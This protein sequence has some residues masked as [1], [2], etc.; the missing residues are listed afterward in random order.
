MILTVSLNSAFQKVLVFD[1]YKEGHVLR[2]KELHQSA[3]GKG[4]NV[5]RAVKNLGGE[6]LV[7]GFVGGING[8]LMKEMLKDEGIKEHLTL[9]EANTRVCTTIISE[10]TNSTTELIE[11]SGK[12]SSKDAASF[13]KEFTSSLKHAKIAAIS[14]TLPPGCDE[15]LYVELVSEAVKRGVKVFVDIWGK[16]LLAAFK[17]KPKPYLVKMNDHEF[18]DTFGERKMQDVFTEFLAAGIEIVIVTFGK[19]G[20]VASVKEGIFGAI[21]E[22][23]TPVNAIGA[24]D[25]M[26]GGFCFAI[27][28]G[29]DI[30]ETLKTGTGSAVASTQT[31]LPA[32][33]TKEAAEKFAKQ[34][35]VKKLC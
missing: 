22:K 32:V 4:I 8:K 17:A 28:K 3:S 35:Q 11:P 6:T 25:S 24:G 26:L 10:K 15:G 16:P 29:Y 23:I 33:F 27:D 31:L 2:A 14:G 34:V 20:L 9:T 18:K 19:D 5:S 30:I 21:P 12:I 1:E 7:T 13:R